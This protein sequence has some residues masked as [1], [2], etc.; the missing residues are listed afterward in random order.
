MISREIIRTLRGI[1]WDFASSRAGYVAPPHWYPGTFIPEL[2]LALIDAIAPPGGMVFDPYCGIG[3]TGWSALRTGRSCQL[4]DANPVAILVSYTSNA[5][6]VLARQYPE[7]ARQAVSDLAGLAKDNNDLLGGGDGGHLTPE[8]DERVIELCEPSP[9]SLLDD[10][11]VGSPNMEPLEI[12]F[13]GSTLETVETVITSFRTADSKFVEL[14]G[15]SMIS[16]VART[17][18]S[19]HASWGHIA[20]NV[21]PKEFRRQNVQAAMSQWMKRTVSFVFQPMLHSE[22]DRANRP[23]SLMRRDWSTSQPDSYGIADLLL[24][25]PPYADAIDYTL[26]QRLS[27][28]LL[29]YDDYRIQRLVASEIGARRKRFK[30]GSRSTWSDE[31]CTAMLEQVRCVKPSGVVCIVLPHKDSGRRNGEADIK[32]ALGGQ[33][34]I[35]FFERDRSIHQSHT[36]QSWTSIKRETIVAFARENEQ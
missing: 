30:S 2:T 12:W 36:R 6:L 4:A 16:A 7:V 24:T 23:V 32:L 29:G 8:I 9:G 11:V 35:P 25:S 15:L 5:L 31:L 1:D 13:E 21:K 18:S 3:T 27:L 10:I 28:Y 14:L 22:S 34:W 20:D 17:L 33:G 26:S 19:Q